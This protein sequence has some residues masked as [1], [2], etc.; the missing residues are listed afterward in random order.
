MKVILYEVIWKK[1][2][3]IEMGFEIW[4]CGATVHEWF[5][6][7]ILVL[8]VQSRNQYHFKSKTG[9]NILWA[10]FLICKLGLAANEIIFKIKTEKKEMAAFPKEF[11]GQQPLY[12]QICL[13]LS[14]YNEKGEALSLMVYGNW[15]PL[16]SLFKIKIRINIKWKSQATL[17][18]Q[19]K[20]SK[21]GRIIWYHRRERK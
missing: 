11:A 1:T 21:I 20:R 17:A 6:I 15:L 7:N 8:A 9:P 2:R 16:H 14:E 5:L 3:N 10:S 13:G 4:K 12:V 18:S 19:T